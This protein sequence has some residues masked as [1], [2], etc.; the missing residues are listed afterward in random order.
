MGDGTAAFPIEMLER[1]FMVFDDIRLAGEPNLVQDD[2]LQSLQRFTHWY[3]WV[4]GEDDSEPDLD[5][6]KDNLRYLDPRSFFVVNIEHWRT[7]GDEAVV[8]ESI[9]KLTLVI[10]TIKEVH[11]NV[12]T[13]IYAM[14]PV[15][16]YFTPVRHEYDSPEFD[17]WAAT[18]ARLQELADHVDVIMP[19]LYT[20]YPDYEADGSPRIWERDRWVRYATANLLQARQYGKPVVSYL[21]PHYHGG[22]GSADP[23]SPF[24]RYWK[25]QPIGAEF[26]EVILE[27]VYQYSDSAAIY[28][29]LPVG[30]DDSA[31]W[32]LAT[33]DFLSE[34]VPAR[35][36]GIDD[37]WRSHSRRLARDMDQRQCDGHDH[38]QQR[39]R[40]AR[41]PGRFDRDPRSFPITMN[42][43][44]DNGSGDDTDPDGTLLAN[45]TVE[46]SGTVSR[47]PDKQRGR[48]L[49]LHTLW[50]FF[51]VG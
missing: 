2:G 49:H 36:R 43:L 29:G 30:W 26:W 7:Y 3:F 31:P 12:V 21:W 40:P 20:F 37:L 23:D 41:C 47:D 24:Y 28:E 6:L 44:A 13:G 5:R 35:P 25:Y 51:R 39:E 17:E 27:T 19:S 16:D 34:V 11:P 4:P 50:K 10:D 18:N 15:R 32:W 38:R 1:E 8:A 33:Q 9:R 22:G 48:H 45:T 46:V 42:V 14:M